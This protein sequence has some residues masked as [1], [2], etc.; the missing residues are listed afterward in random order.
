MNEKIL[1]FFRRVLR[2]DVLPFTLMFL[3]V[4]WFIASQINLK[5]NCKEFENEAKQS[6]RGIVIRIY[7]ERLITIDVKSNDVRL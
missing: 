1:N 4:I 5:Y 6:Y 7:Q 3:F 2:K